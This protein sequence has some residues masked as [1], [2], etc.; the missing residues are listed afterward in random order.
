MRRTEEAVARQIAAM[1][2]HTFEIGLF[3]PDVPGK[4]PVMIPRT[5]DSETLLRSV[6][7]LCKENREGR[8]IFCRPKGEHA[9]SLVDDLSAKA[10]LQ[11][12]DSGFEP[13]L[14]VETAPHNFQAW[15][16]HGRVLDPVLSTAVAKALAAEFG[17][18]AG[19]ADWRH[20]G[21]L[22]GFTN[23]KLKHFD[24]GTGHYPFVR[25]VEDGRR[26]YQRAD[27]FVNQ[28]ENEIALRREQEALRANRCSTSSAQQPTRLKGIED[29]RS[30]ARYGGDGTRIDL[31]FGIYALA[32]GLSV[33][34]AADAIRSR[35]LSHKGSESRQHDYVERTIKKAL[36]AI[37]NAPPE[38]SR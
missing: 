5:W 23:R 35:D 12:K 8:N 27:Y 1:G 15:L 22:A 33:E 32:H 25:I 4:G 6:G 19:A 11:M 30:D 26:S 31:A 10:V 28:V 20:F 14:V 17:G 18:D 37:E 2:C 38:R 3:K 24:E 34:E 36:L 9:L 13:A 29:F 21:R 7:W 16:N